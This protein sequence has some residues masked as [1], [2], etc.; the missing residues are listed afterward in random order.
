MNE[1]ALKQTPPSPPARKRMRMIHVNE[2][3]LAGRLTHDPQIRTAVG[4]KMIVHLN[5][6]VNR[7]YR[8]GSGRLRQEVSFVPV[9]VWNR[10]A[11][12]CTR[13]LV[14]GSAVYLEGRLRSDR[15]KTSG[16]DARTAL[17]VQASRMQFITKTN[18]RFLKREAMVERRAA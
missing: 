8:S 6:A 14:K 18:A 10:L 3:R 2:V 15:W 5:L 7:S 4:D 17:K 16:G 11:A 9:T 1:S 13:R 12:H